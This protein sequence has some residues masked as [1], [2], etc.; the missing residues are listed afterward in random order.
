MDDHSNKVRKHGGTKLKEVGDRKTKSGTND[1]EK[2]YK[3]ESTD[4]I[5]EADAAQKSPE[6]VRD[7]TNNSTPEERGRTRGRRTEKD[8]GVFGKD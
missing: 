4:I 5:N 7:R 1:K 2:T 8:K 3:T 6:K